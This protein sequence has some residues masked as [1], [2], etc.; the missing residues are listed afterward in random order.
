MKVNVTQTKHKRNISKRLRG[1]VMFAE[2]RWQSILSALEKHKT[3]TVQFLSQELGVS[4]VTVR[5]DLSELEEKGLLKRTHG[6]AIRVDLLFEPAYEEKATANLAQKE[7]IAREA[8]A[9]IKPGEIIFLDAGTTTM[10]IA[11]A[12]PAGMEITVA[13]NALNIAQELINKG[14]RTI[15]I[16]GEIRKTM[17]AV[18]PDTVATLSKYYFN[19]LFLGT[20]GF[21]LKE[22]LTTPS[23]AEAEVKAAMLRQSQYKYLVSD[24]SKYSHI[25][26]AKF[27]ELRDLNAVIT[28]PGIPKEARQE[29]E[30]LGL[31]LILTPGV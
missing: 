9:E 30:D 19:R 15:I 31:R 5:K 24:S 27:G 25:S 22:G 2:E 29:I 12:L 23:P 20:N 13:T 11:R 26:F 28:D 18:G 10:A 21:S 16:G 14:L 7:Q 6:G 4:P 3:V 1:V 8:V 17:A